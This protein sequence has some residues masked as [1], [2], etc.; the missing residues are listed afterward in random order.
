MIQRPNPYRRIYYKTH[1][2][3]QLL[4]TPS[5]KLI[6]VVEGVSSSRLSSEKIRLEVS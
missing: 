4:G 2:S 5:Q 6:K 1:K 3:G